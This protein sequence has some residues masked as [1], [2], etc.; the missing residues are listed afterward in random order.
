MARFGGGPALTE[1]LSIFV[2]FISAMLWIALVIGGG[3]YHY[4][5]IGQRSSWKLFG[6]TIAGQLSILILS[7]II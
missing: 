2:V 3:E 5:R 4:R 6:R 1:S 7:H